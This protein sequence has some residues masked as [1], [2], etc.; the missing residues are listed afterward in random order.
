MNLLYN[1]RTGFHCLMQR[2]IRV[3]SFQWVGQGK[4]GKGQELRRELADGREA[5]D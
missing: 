2:K 1:G 4:E 3:Y 5:G